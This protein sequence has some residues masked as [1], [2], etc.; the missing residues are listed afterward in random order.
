MTALGTADYLGWDMT[1]L[2]ASA[3]EIGT[4]NCTV[5]EPTGPVVALELLLLW[6]GSVFPGRGGSSVLIEVEIAD[7]H[8]CVHGSHYL[9][10]RSTKHLFNLPTASISLFHISL[11]P[12]NP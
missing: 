8:S 2:G 9:L 3:L 11:F 7:S 1:L 5:L 12:W 10:L 4:V 6:R